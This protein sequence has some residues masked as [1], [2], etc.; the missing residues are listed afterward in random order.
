[1]VP[2]KAGTFGTMGRNIFYDPSF[3]NVDFSLFKNFKYKERLNAQF[4][5]E[6]FNVFNHPNPANPY[7]GVVNSALGND[8][9]APQR[10]RL[11]MRHARHRQRQSDPR[12]G[13]LC[14]TCNSD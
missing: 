3:K 5:V 2:P 1:M 11:R 10:L 12:I 13:R 9:S 14:A 7:G 4:R 6:F 8:P